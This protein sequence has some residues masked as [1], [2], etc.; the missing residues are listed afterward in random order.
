VNHIRSSYGSL[1][2]AEEALTAVSPA[3]TLEGAGR[4]KTIA[5][6]TTALGS[7]MSAA[8]TS[9]PSLTHHPMWYGLRTQLQETGPSTTR[10]HSASA[11]RPAGYVRRLRKGACVQACVPL[12]SVCRVPPP[13]HPHPLRA[14]CSGSS[15]LYTVFVPPRGVPEDD[16]DVPSVVS[17]LSPRSQLAASGGAAGGAEA[18]GVGGGMPLGSGP[19]AAVAGRGRAMSLMPRGAGAG[20]GAASGAGHPADLGLHVDTT[21]LAA[22]PAGD[23]SV[24]A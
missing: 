11:E 9:N 20:A 8:P 2:R 3:H 5:G 14:R 12:G 19:A 4:R 10:P 6:A 13:P 1:M 23:T 22:A 18:G 17:A 15:E 21:A 16:A 7:A 24:D